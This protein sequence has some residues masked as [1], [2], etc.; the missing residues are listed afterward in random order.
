MTTKAELE[1]QAKAAI[2]EQVSNIDA[3]VDARLVK[4]LTSPYTLMYVVLYTA[5][6]FG[7]GLL[8]GKGW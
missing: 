8:I 5:A 1:A 7:L 2:A 6:C 3:A 4:V